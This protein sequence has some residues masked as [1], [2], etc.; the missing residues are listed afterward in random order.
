MPANKKK[1]EHHDPFKRPGNDQL[2]AAEDRAAGKPTAMPMAIAPRF[3]YAEGGQTVF[4]SPVTELIRF[5]E[6][7]LAKCENEAMFLTTDGKTWRR[8]IFEIR[9]IN[10][11]V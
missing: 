1:E 4:D 11:E 3:S 2:S 8:F 10:E 7:L 5:G 9:P 6:L